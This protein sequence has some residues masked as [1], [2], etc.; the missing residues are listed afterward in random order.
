MPR[1]VRKNGQF[2]IKLWWPG[3]GRFEVHTFRDLSP[4]E[5]HEAMVYE[6]DVLRGVLDRMEETRLKKGAT[7][8]GE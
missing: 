2:A 8:D 1:G 5:F 4:R 7:P 6:L 3:G